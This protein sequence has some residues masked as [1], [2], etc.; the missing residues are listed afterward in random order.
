MARSIV[1]NRAT[2]G[3][4]HDR[5]YDRL[6]RTTTDHTINRDILRLIAR[7]HDAFN[8]RRNE[9][10]HESQKP[11]H[12]CWYPCRGKILVVRAGTTILKVVQP[13]WS[14]RS[15]IF[16]PRTWCRTTGGTTN[17]IAR[18]VARRIVRL[19]Y[20]RSSTIGGATIHDWNICDR[21]RFSMMLYWFSAGD[22]VLRLVVRSFYTIYPRF[23]HLSVATNS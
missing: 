8:D 7:L 21:V 9:G 18:P 15:R 4:D 12:I 2:I 11:L 6:L 19:C 3:S 5:S 20:P 10:G 13:L 14:D 1:G 16:I 23:Q 17:R 22:H